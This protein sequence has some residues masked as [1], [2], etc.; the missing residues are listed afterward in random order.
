[1]QGK[2]TIKRIS[3]TTSRAP[4]PAWTALHKLR[5]AMVRPDRDSDLLSGEIEV[6]ETFVGGV[7]VGGK[8]GRARGQKAIVVI[9]IEREG[10]RPRQRRRGPTPPTK[11]KK[12]EPRRWRAGPFGRVRMRVILDA[13]AETLEA[14]IT[15]T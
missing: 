1:M 8:P 10:T 7:A 11:R 5:Y 15:D 2:R 12:G 9:A 3:Q 14:F 4:K 6:D 13:S